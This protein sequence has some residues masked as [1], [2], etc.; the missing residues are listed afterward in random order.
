MRVT[1]WRD[2]AAN[3]ASFKEMLQWWRAVANAVSD[4]NGSRFELQTSCTRDE[5]VTARPTGWSV[6]IVKSLNFYPIFAFGF[7]IL[8]EY[9]TKYKVFGKSLCTYIKKII[10][11][12]HRNFPNT[13]YNYVDYSIRLIQYNANVATFPIQKFFLSKLFSGLKLQRLHPSKIKEVQ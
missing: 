10:R 3:T 8:P 1:S 9:T 13:L 5:R 2:P 7:S 6:L 11:K 4:W 12:V